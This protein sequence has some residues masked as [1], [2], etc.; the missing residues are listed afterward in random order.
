MPKVWSQPSLADEALAVALSEL[1][2]PDLGNGRD[3]FSW[4][5]QAIAVVVSHDVAHHNAKIRCQRS[6]PPTSRRARLLR[7]VLAVVAQAPKGYG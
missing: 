5:S 7:D 6:W 2:H 1:R 3:N 4:Y